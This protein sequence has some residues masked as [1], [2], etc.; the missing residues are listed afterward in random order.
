MAVDIAPTLYDYAGIDANK[1]LKAKPTLPMVGVSFK[2][3][4]SGE[5]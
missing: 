1:P 3:Y 4:F 5:G 2:R